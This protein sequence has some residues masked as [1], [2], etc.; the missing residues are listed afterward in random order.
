MET[1]LATAFGYKIELLKGKVDGGDELLQAASNVF[2][3]SG[4]GGTL[5][6]AIM[7]L[8]CKH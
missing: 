7:C 2:N 5:G 8:H 6:V 1:I 3:T 4:R